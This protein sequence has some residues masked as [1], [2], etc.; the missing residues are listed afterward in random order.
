[1]KAM[2][3]KK[4]QTLLEMQEL[5]KP[6]PTQDQILVAVHACGVCRTDLHILNHELPSEIPEPSYPL[7][8]GH[9]VVGTIVALGSQVR[10]FKKGERVGVPWLGMS[11]RK[12]EYCKS[13]K[14]NLCDFAK[15]TGYH[16]PGGYAE[17]CIAD[18]RYCFPIPKNFSDLQAAPLL[19]A[20]LI[21][22]RAYRMCGS[23]KNIGF[24]GF[25]SS[26]HILAQI[27]HYEKKQVYAFT[28]PNDTQGQNFARQLGASWAGSS[29]Q[30][31][32]VL[33]DAAILFAPV[34]ALIPKALQAVKKGGIV[35]C[36][37]IHMSEIPAFAYK[38]LWGERTLCSVAN[39]TRQD[40]EDLLALAA[41]VPVKTECQIY[42]LS[43]A[44]QALE[45]LRSGT[46]LASAV[47]KIRS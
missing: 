37:G 33:L 4:N 21:G 22:Y 19:C 31:A 26:A 45:D 34:G 38:N 30:V 17:Y 23:A 27:A 6:E 32:P 11:C 40:G 42:S 28:R 1:M 25:G 2:V 24:F 39:L 36:A 43:E 44:N 47:L 35:V 10:D 8:L 13:G 12:C 20:G 5:P 7:I 41:K 15:F 18:A 9:Q 46:L 16:L 14:E 3:L 29:E